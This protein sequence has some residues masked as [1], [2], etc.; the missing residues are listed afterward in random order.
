MRPNPRH[1][2]GWATE[3]SDG[4]PIRQCSFQQA[5]CLKELKRERF[6]PQPLFNFSI[7][8]SRIECPALGGHVLNSSFLCKVRTESCVK[9]FKDAYSPRNRSST[10]ENKYAP[11][12]TNCSSSS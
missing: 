1:L 6:F 2:I 8:Y 11:P 5:Q 4:L 10:L 12:P 9:L 7:R 3:A